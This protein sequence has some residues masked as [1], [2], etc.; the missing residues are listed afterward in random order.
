M[1]YTCVDQSGKQK[2]EW[3][4]EMRL[5]Q[6]DRKTYEIEITGRGTYFHAIVGRHHYGTISVFQTMM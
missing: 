4:G 2:K 6:K 3:Q 1:E 5:I